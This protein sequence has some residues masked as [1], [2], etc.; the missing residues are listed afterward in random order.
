[1]TGRRSMQTY[2][3]RVSRAL[4][5][6]PGHITGRVA[7]AQPVQ[8][9]RTVGVV[10]MEATYAEG[11]LIGNS[12]SYAVG[13]AS[14]FPPDPVYMT[15]YGEMGDLVQGSALVS[16]ISGYDIAPI[17]LPTGWH[18]MASGTV[19]SLDYCIGW[20]SSLDTITHDVDLGGWTT[21]GSICGI[22]TFTFATGDILITDPLP[23]WSWDLKVTSAS[24]AT[25]VESQAMAVP[26]TTWGTRW[27]ITS[28]L[29]QSGTGYPTYGATADVGGIANIGNDVPPYTL[30]ASILYP[31]DYEIEHSRY[32]GEGVTVSFAPSGA[33]GSFASFGLGWSPL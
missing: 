8:R 30:Y 32:S 6:L 23:E 16:I 2:E 19:G 20:A 4:Q 17:T 10:G 22:T 24:T 13:L 25:G 33:T 21:P 28:M 26:P 31:T 12:S 18:E 3:A 5:F 27:S 7:S 15:Q 1:M 9:R 14:P 11:P 29:R